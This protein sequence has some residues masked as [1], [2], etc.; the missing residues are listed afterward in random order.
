[1]LHTYKVNYVIAVI[2]WMKT[3]SHHLKW[4]TPRWAIRHLRTFNSVTCHLLYQLL[5]LV[6]IV[7][8]YMPKLR[9]EQEN[10]NSVRFCTFFTDDHKTGVWLMPR[11]SKEQGTGNRE[12]GTGNREQGT[13]LK[14]L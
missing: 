4:L 7:N 10:K 12:Q 3:Y 1:V 6:I 11:Y 13:E 14:I 2:S 5:I 8:Q 9:Q